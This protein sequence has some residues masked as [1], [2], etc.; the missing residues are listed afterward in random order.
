[1][2]A[3]VQIYRPQPNVYYQQQTMPQLRGNGKVK[4]QKQKDVRQQIPVWGD[5]FPRNYGQQ[6]SA[7][8]HQRNAE[9]KANKQAEKAYK[10]EQKA[11]ARYREAPRYYQAPQYRPQYQQAVPQYYEYRQPQYEDRARQY[12]RPNRYY[13]QPSY[14]EPG[15]SQQYNAQPYYPQPY[16]FSGPVYRSQE[17]TPYYGD[18]Y[19]SADNGFDVQDV[20]RDIIFSVLSGGGLDSLGGL[21]GAYLGNGSYGQ[22]L[23]SYSSYGTRF[24]AASQ[25]SYAA[26]GRRYA[27]DSPYDGYVGPDAYYPLQILSGG[28]GDGGMFREMFSELLAVGYDEGY[29]QGLAA[30]RTVNRRDAYFNDPYAYDNEFCSPYSTSLGDNRQFLSQGYELGYEDALNGLRDYEQMGES[31]DIDLLSILLGVAS[32]VM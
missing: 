32:Q 10:Q 21:P 24:P 2:P 6:R 12:A 22:F 5:V 15:Y 14:P 23:P 31:G 11:I 1:M 26:S 28:A 9:R 27:D 19:D 25:Y 18:G 3:P 17:Y 7:E 29:R 13:G 30:R 8:V 4:H 20:L 16:D